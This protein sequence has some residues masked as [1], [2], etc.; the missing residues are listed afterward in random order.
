M[1]DVEIN[2]CDI[3]GV[4]KQVS[5]KYYYYNIHCDC[6]NSKK[7]PHFEIVWYCNNCT[8]VPPRKITGYYPPMSDEELK[9]VERTKKLKKLMK[10]LTIQSTLF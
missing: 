5:R 2:K 10:K 6:C 3:C 7:S 4:P 9:I 8:P 1:G